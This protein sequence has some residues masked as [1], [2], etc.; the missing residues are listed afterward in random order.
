MKVSTNLKAGQANA[1][2]VAVGA[3]N[4]SVIRQVNVANY[5]VLSTISQ[6]NSATV[7]QT[8]TNSGAVTA[9]AVGGTSTT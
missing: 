6:S 7:T 5:N 3:A 2:A 1:T 8:A 4:V 9:A